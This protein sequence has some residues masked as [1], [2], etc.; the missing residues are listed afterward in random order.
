[1]PDDLFRRLSR[2]RRRWIQAADDTVAEADRIFG[3]AQAG[4][5]RQHARAAAKRCERAAALYRKAG[6]GLLAKQLFAAASR[7]YCL[8]RDREG[9]R[10]AQE[11][12]SALST[13][14][15]DADSP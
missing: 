9:A 6:L 14:W 12:W 1:M 4:Q 7:Y 5:K 8:C 11:R 15:E 13:Y 2:N 10:L 3:Q